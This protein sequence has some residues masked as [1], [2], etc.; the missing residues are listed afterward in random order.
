M[1]KENQMQKRYGLWTAIGMVVGT[2]IG[3][4][5]FFKAQSVLSSNGGNM[6]GSLLTV[7]LVGLV[8]L[9]CSY[10]FSLLAART[11]KVNGLV[12]YSEIALGG[13]YAYGV[14]WFITTIFYPTLTSCLAWISASYTLVLFGMSGV[15][16]GCHLGLAA[17]YLLVSFAMNVFS[18]SLSG[19]FQVSTTFIKLVPLV[20]MAIVGTI[21][22]LFGGAFSEGQVSSTMNVGDYASGGFFGAVVAFAF[23][24]EGWIFATC[25]NSELKDA[26]RDLPR[27]LFL[28]ALVII[29]VYLGYFVGIFGTLTSEEILASEN[30]PMDAFSTLFG[31][32]VVGTVAY[33]FVVISCLGTMNGLV[34]ASCRG[35]YSV[36]VRG[37]GP[38]PKYFAHVDPKF[39]MPI[40]SSVFGFVMVLFWLLQWQ[41]GFINGGLPR[42]LSFENDEL[43]I[44]SFY[45]FCIPIYIYIM[46]ECRDLGAVKRFVIPSLAVAASVFMVFAAVYKYRTDTLYYLLIFAIF[47]AL[48]MMFYRTNGKTVGAVIYKKMKNVLGLERKVK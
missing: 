14:G 24:F 15:H 4:G 36:A 45:A 28:G 39:N 48:G 25:I 47:T 2:V 16:W 5:V 12:D 10:C 7:L 42:F 21:A 6:A 17:A 1:E 44:I 43:P 38:M 30:L 41:I 31:S 34:L 26:K 23:A 40:R 20:V 8:M 18:P 3:S 29:A 35:I 13:L 27:A 9:V 22:G 32:R 46:K 19:K 37:E 33:V 11:V